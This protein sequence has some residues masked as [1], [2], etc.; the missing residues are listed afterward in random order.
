MPTFS[1]LLFY[2]S[3]ADSAAS[4]ARGKDNTPDTTGPLTGLLVF[5]GLLLLTLAGCLYGHVRDSWC[6]PRRLLVVDLDTT[7]PSSSSA[8]PPPPPH[9]PA[10]AHHL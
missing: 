10:S 4:S 8:S 1:S 2:L 9:P 3:T 7:S 5:V 6:S